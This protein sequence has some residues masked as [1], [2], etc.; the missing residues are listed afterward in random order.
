M[1]PQDSEVVSTKGLSNSQWRSTENKMEK[2]LGV[3]QGRFLT[4]GGK[5]ILKKYVKRTPLSQLSKKQGDSQFWQGL[6]EINPTYQ[7]YCLKAIGDGKMYKLL[8]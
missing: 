2:K 1:V 6:M 8:V 7:Q 4:L 5:D 3:W